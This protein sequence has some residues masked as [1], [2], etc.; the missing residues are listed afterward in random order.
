MVPE[1]GGTSEFGFCS[2]SSQLVVVYYAV[3]TFSWVVSYLRFTTVSLLGVTVRFGG[4]ASCSARWYLLHYFS[5]G[6]V[7]P[8]AV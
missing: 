4:R 6:L 2:R 5:S 8:G 7:G 3:V 1:V